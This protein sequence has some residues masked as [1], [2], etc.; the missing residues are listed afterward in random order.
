M[1]R[2]KDMHPCLCDFRM[3][4]ETPSTRRSLPLQPSPQIHLP[5]LRAFELTEYHNSSPTTLQ[6]S[7]GQEVW[8]A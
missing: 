5:I 1:N 7:A 4:S 8:F 3:K 6:P 2:C